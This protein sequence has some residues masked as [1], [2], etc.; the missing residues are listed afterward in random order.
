MH[1]FTP[2]PLKKHIETIVLEACSNCLILLKVTTESHNTRLRLSIEAN[3]TTIQTYPTLALTKKDQTERI[4]VHG[5]INSTGK[6]T[7]YSG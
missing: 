1:R 4:I 3:R 5:G 7:V 2:N 6:I